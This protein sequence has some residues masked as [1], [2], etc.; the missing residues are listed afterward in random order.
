MEHLPVAMKGLHKVSVC[1]GV[2]PVSA[3][4]FLVLLKGKTIQGKENPRRL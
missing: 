3:F 1:V 2:T 4:L